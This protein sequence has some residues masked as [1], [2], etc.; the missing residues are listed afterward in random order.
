MRVVS[1]AELARLAGVSK[2][3]VTKAAAS[4]L[5]PALVGKR[6]DVDHPAAA[7]WLQKKLNPPT[8]KPPKK[9]KKAPSKPKSKKTPAAKKTP[10]KPK[11]PTESEEPPEL[12]PVE[13]QDDATV[14]S[15]GEMK[16]KDLVA[17]FGTGAQFKE[18]TLA[19]KNLESIRA[20]QVKNEEKEGALI[21]RD[22]VKTHLFGAIENTN[23]RLL[24]DTPKTL[25]K[26]IA[27]HV[28]AGGTLEEAEEI[29]RKVLSTQLKGVKALA[30]RA[31]EDA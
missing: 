22:L 16:L 5:K 6:I 25:S 27:S 15:Y 30:Q 3:A 12:P 24:T 21:S 11:A 8:S 18:W 29:I 17:K 23:L 10:T 9:P 4:F 14:K 2:A 1:K 20:L 31:L 28:K 19:K 13:L 26:R 7:A